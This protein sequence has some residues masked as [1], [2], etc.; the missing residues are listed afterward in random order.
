MSSQLGLLCLLHPK[1]ASSKGRVEQLL[2]SSLPY[3]HSPKSQCTAWT[4]FTPSLRKGAPSLQVPAETKHLVIGG[5]ELYT[6]KSALSVQLDDPSYKV[7]HQTVKAEALYSKD[8]DL[9]AWRP[10]GGYFSRTDS[11]HAGK[12]VVVMTA[13]FVCKDVESA[14]RV[15]ARLATYA[16]W[17]KENEPEVLTYAVLS[18]GKEPKE[19]LMFERYKNLGAIKAHGSSKEF[20][21]M[22]KDIRGYL[23]GATKMNEW[24]EIKGSFVGNVVGGLTG[25]KL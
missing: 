8:E 19:V 21:T 20:K 25:A 9:V 11:T 6:D 23:G 1:D 13:T 2:Q 17:V 16:A 18:R 12:G 5:F 15:V 4:Y 24:E 3:Y 14:E 7:Y 22:F 10:R